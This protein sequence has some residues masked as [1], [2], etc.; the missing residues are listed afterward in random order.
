MIKQSEKAL[1]EI[2][3]SRYYLA[4][5]SIGIAEL[6]EKAFLLMQFATENN[7]IKENA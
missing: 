3:A 5:A 4:T 7:V 6:V 1:K 2:E